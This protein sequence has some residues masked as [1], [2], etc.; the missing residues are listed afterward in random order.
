[1]N[2]SLEP[3]AEGVD[4]RGKWW[5]ADPG[6]SEPGKM[7]HEGQRICKG[8]VWMW[9]VRGGHIRDPSFKTLNFGVPLLETGPCLHPG[10][11]RM[12]LW[13]DGRPPESPW[14]RPGMMHANSIF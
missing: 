14:G 12:Q 5:K 4:I 1:M 13:R 2:V 11:L 9:A 6:D 3:P 8:R 10:W 7:P